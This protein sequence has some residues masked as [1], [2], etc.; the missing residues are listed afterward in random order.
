MR[1]ALQESLGADPGRELRSLHAELL[2]PAGEGGPGPVPLRVDTGSFEKRPIP[3][4]AEDGYPIPVPDP[5]PEPVRTGPHSA[6]AEPGG[7]E[8]DEPGP[9][10]RT[11]NLRPRLNSFVGREPE[12]DAIRSDVQRAR[13]VT[14]TGPGGS[15]KTRLA[16]EAAAGLPQAWLVELAPLDRPEAV[17]GAVV[18]ALGLRETVLM[19]NEMAM[20]GQDDPLGLLVEY[21]AP[22]SQL[23]ILDNCEHVIGAAAELAETL[24]TRCPGLTVLATSREPLGVPGELVRPVEPLPPDP[25]RRL[26]MERAAVVRPDADTVLHDSEAV[27]EICR[28]L[29]GLPLAIELAAARLRLL[30]P[31][32]IADRLDDRFRLLTSGSRTALPRQQTLRAVVDWSWDLLDEPER[33][34]LREASV[35]AGGWD[36]AAAEAVCTGS[37][38]G[39][40]PGLVADLVGALVDKSLIVA[41]PYAPYDEDGSGGMRYRMLETIHEYATERAAEV[42]E[43]APRP[44]GATAR[45]CVTS[46]RRPSRCCAPPRNCPGS[47]AWRPSSTTSG[48]P[49]TGR[50]SP[51]PR[52]TSARSSSPWAGSGGCATSAARAWSGRIACCGWARRSMRRAPCPGEPF[53]RCRRWRPLRRPGPFR[54]AGRLP[55][56]SRPRGVPSAARHADAGAHAA[57]VHAGGDRAAGRRAVSAAPGVHRAGTG[58]LREGGPDAA[59]M[60][61]IVWPLTAF[62]LSGS[63]DVRPAMDVAVANCRVYG[64]EWEIGVALMFRT[65]MVVDAPGGMPGVDDDLAELRV[66]SRRVGDR[67]MRA[68]VCS[69]AGEAAM[70]RSLHGEAKG[71]YEEAL[72][73]AFEVGA[74]AEAP[75]LMARLAEIA[76]RAGD[77][78]RALTAL[79]EADAAADRYGVT[80][81]RSFVCLLRA[82][83]ALDDGEVAFA[84]ELWQQACEMSARGTPPP[85]FMATLN[86]VEALVTA[87]E[88]GPEPG[89]RKMVDALVAAV[90]GRC[91]DVVTAGL[92]E[93]AARLL[94]ELG[95]HP[96]AARLLAAGTRWRGG[97]PRPTPECT[98]AE[99]TEAA[100][101]AA[102][103]PGGYESERTTGAGF[104]PV[105]ALGDLA[106]ALKEYD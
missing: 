29:D 84:R 44:S 105:D 12:L 36:L 48:R 51:V 92:V 69:A 56:R 2:A 99:R 7:D 73:L 62:F 79:D 30:T 34:V 106:E 68:Q 39:S 74:H 76:Y 91:A 26:F 49:C 10:E 72:R 8:T 75:F 41:T 13:L 25:A 101:R 97:H 65:H 78:S 54:P 55:R 77:R 18:S 59:T 5:R 35:F 19:T 93:S 58:L 37:G 47:T 89:L 61:G 23:L 33:T 45:G 104:T 71:E 16:E 52:R 82:Q 28:R 24:L 103:G 90:A 66:L 31:R 32:Q 80:D 63:H 102:L 85:Q 3:R 17:P 15:G 67:W 88:S 42:P 14:L 21:C 38:T 98:D 4:S 70:A 81:S 83:L 95:D 22:R 64:G 60:P 20:V 43:C 100:A 96:R 27:D 9:R 1:R 94:S 57:P 11:G 6:A 40:V 87:A 46:S 86:W 53:G 50:S